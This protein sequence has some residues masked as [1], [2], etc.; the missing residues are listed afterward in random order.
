MLNNYNRFLDYSVFLR[1]CNAYLKSRIPGLANIKIIQKHVN[2][3]QVLWEKEEDLSLVFAVFR[4]TLVL[5]K[6][7]YTD[8]P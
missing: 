3:H 7:Q 4:D 5:Q 2:E 6:L 1:V 8:T